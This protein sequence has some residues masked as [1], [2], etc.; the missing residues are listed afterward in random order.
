[1]KITKYHLIPLLMVLSPVLADSPPIVAAARQQVGKTVQY[2]PEYVVLK[3]PGGDVGEEKGVCSDVVIRALRSGLKQDLQQL[4]HEDMAANFSAYPKNW[5]LRKPDKNIDHR[6]VLN[7]QTF[8][9]RRGYQL[10][11]TQVGADF[12]PGDLV[13]C[14][15]PP[16]LPHIM[17]VSDKTTPDGRPLV[18]HNIGL[19]AQEEDRLFSFPLTG[20][21]RWK[22][23]EKK[24]E[25]A[26]KSN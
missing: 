5:D 20:H 9:K 6:R 7:L 15:V 2:D 8:F 22:E 21:Y 14:T 17:V 23:V 11:V 4:V 25:T 18:L 16:N 12:K 1:M 13:T 24:P 26:T 3:Y 10:P 19:G